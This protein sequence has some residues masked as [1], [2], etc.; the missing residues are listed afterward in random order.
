MIHTLEADGIQ[1]DFGMRRILSDVYLKCETGKISGLLGRNGQGKTCLMNII[2]GTLNS[3]SNSIRF[4][5]N[6]IRKVS[7]RPDL[8][9]YLP[10]F[11]FI[12]KELTVKKVLDDFELSNADLETRFP[13]FKGRCDL[14]VNQ[15]SG[16]QWRTLELYIIV[17]TPSLFAML[18]EPFTHLNPIQIENI[19]AFLLEEKANKGFL[20]TDHMYTHLLDI[21]NTVYLLKDGRTHLT[22]TVEDLEELGYIRIGH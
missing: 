22:K 10:Q 17:K 1:L 13:E 6:V 16:G 12:P 7:K 19:K 18:D 14:K 5:G 21:S 4:D 15:L 9:L 20:I 2:L 3:S 11:N 8:L